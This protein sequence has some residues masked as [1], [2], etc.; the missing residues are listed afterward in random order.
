MCR[1]IGPEQLL[2]LLYGKILQR[3]TKLHAGIVDENIDRPDG[4]FD[5]GNPLADVLG[6]GHIETGHR[7]R[8]PGCGQACSGS[9]K[10]VALASVQNHGGAMLGEP[11][12]DGEPDPLRRSRDERPLAGQIEQFE[13]HG[14][15]FSM[16]L[17]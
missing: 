6:D 16:H 2:P 10:L 11:S 8:V 3:R 9:L 13:C 5:R 4:P 14:G 1:N 17:V 15:T 7:N 12:R